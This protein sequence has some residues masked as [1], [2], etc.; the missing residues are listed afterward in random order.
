MS[1]WCSP[2]LQPTFPNLSYNKVA[3]IATFTGINDS[4]FDKSGEMRSRV[5]DEL[6][7]RGLNSLAVRLESGLKLLN[8]R[9]IK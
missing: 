6:Q 5:T 9:V 4:I 8:K 2:R 3:A 7:M 1:S